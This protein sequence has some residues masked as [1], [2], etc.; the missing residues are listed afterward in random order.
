MEAGIETDQP[1]GRKTELAREAHIAMTTAAGL[2]D[3]AAIH[4]GGRVGVAQNGMFTVAVCADRRLW[5]ALR[6]SLAMHAGLKLARAV[7]VPHAAGF[8][9]HRPESGRLGID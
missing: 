1:V 5:N 4:R 7:R 8:R 6:Y 2:A 9:Y 3:V